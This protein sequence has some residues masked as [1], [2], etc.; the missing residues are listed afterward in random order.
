M[1]YYVCMIKSEKLLVR[2]TKEEKQKFSKAARKYKNLSAFLLSAG[3]ML[4]KYHRLIEQAE[5]LTNAQN[6]K[7]SVIE[8]REK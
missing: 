2:I 6:L 8:V 1:V 4:I 7:V 5:K 3:R